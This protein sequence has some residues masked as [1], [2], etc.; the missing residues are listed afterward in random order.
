MDIE[1]EES[2]HKRFESKEFLKVFTTKKDT[3]RIKEEVSIGGTKENVGTLLWTEVMSRRLDT[4]VVL[5]LI[6][7]SS[8]RDPKTSRM[9]SS[10]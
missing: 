6:H 9:P 1:G 5:S 3:Y 7:I 2:L 10:A 8:P 4:P